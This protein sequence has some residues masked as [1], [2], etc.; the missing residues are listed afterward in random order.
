MRLSIALIGRL[1]TRALNR[2]QRLI[3]TASSV[4]ENERWQRTLSV[5]DFT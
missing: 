4:C 1:K 5:Q 3:R 2:W